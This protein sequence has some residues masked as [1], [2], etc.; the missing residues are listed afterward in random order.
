MIPLSLPYI[1]KN[2]APKKRVIK[3]KIPSQS[4]SPSNE[5]ETIRP[6]DVPFRDQLC[7]APYAPYSFVP[8]TPPLP[9]EW[10]ASPS[11][12]NDILQQS[13]Q[14]YYQQQ[15]QEILNQLKEERKK[16]AEEVLSALVKFGTLDPE[17]VLFR[18]LVSPILVLYTDLSLDSYHLEP[19]LLEK[20][21]KLTSRIRFSPLARACL[22]KVFS[23]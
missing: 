13:E 15:T 14:E 22:H 21:R 20:N 18:E 7:Y 19:D 16:E 12:L 8:P 11:E 3:P 4:P 1:K 9:S 23:L 6:P 10:V 5:V 17:I 2:M